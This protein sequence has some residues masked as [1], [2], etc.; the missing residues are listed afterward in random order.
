MGPGGARRRV[1]DDHSADIVSAPNSP[2]LSARSTGFISEEGDQRFR[3]QIER[4]S[5]KIS[6]PLRQE[7]ALLDHG[8]VSSWRSEICP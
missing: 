6:M 3:L 7:L 2:S 5:A 4:Q 1:F 8:G